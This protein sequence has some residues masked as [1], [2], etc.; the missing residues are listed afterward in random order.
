MKPLIKGPA[1]NYPAKVFTTGFVVLTLLSIPLFW[2]RF[3]CQTSLSVRMPDDAQSVF[4]RPSGL[5]PTEFENDPNV[6]YHSI[7]SAN[8]HSEE[9]GLQS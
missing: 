2:F 7:V 9:E 3:F 6:V 5:V 8:M 1:L 4:I